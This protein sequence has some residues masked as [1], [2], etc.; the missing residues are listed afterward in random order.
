[1]K[2]SE[3]QAD[4][5]QLES[6]S[7]ASFLIHFLLGGVALVACSLTGSLVIAIAHSIAYIYH[8]GPPDAETEQ[9]LSQVI[10]ATN[11]YGWLLMWFGTC[12]TATL[13]FARHR[14]PSRVLILPL[15]VGA[16][17]AALPFTLDHP[18]ASGLVPQ[19]GRFASMLFVSFLGSVLGRAYRHRVNR[20]LELIFQI[21]HAA[22]PGQL[23]LRTRA[24]MGRRSPR[25]V[26]CVALPAWHRQYF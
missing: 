14:T 23:V 24:A 13:S 12:L 7:F 10:L 1:L 6:K 3:N 2:R 5:A 22:S 15:A 11:R 4:W 8:L 18:Q 16:W 9:L 25:I 19:L 20:K 26:P 17:L 21:R